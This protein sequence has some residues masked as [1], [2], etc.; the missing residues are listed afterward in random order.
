MKEKPFPKEPLNTF[1]VDII[2]N[3]LVKKSEVELEQIEKGKK[4]KQKIL[5]IKNV[6]VETVQAD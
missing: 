4:L 5:R 1:R 2:N 6:I 3:K